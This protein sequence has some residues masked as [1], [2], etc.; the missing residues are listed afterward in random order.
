M[1]K[2]LLIAVGGGA[3]SVL[4]YLLGGWVQMLTGSLFPV[5]TLAV[6]L[7]GCLVIGLLRAM[8]S[9]RIVPEEY[10]VAVF[11]GVLGGFTTFSAFGWETFSL[12]DDRQFARAGANVLASVGV[13]LVAVWI[14]Y[15]FG[16]KVFGV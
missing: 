6:N 2:L 13:G 7:V 15:R 1:A 16:Q 5:G 14:G 4:R 11:V 9:A 3:G 12:L 8:F 10:S